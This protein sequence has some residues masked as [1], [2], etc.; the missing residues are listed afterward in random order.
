[1]PIFGSGCWSLIFLLF[2]SIVRFQSFCL[3]FGHDLLFFYNV[4]ILDTHRDLPEGVHDL[5]DD[6]LGRLVEL[7]DSGII[8]IWKFWFVLDHVIADAHVGILRSNGRWGSLSRPAIFSYVSSF[9]PKTLVHPRRL[10][11]TSISLLFESVIRAQLTVKIVLRIQ[12][13]LRYVRWQL[14]EA[15]YFSQ[16]V[17]VVILLLVLILLRLFYGSEGFSADKLHFI[18]FYFNLMYEIWMIFIY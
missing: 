6:L 8:W 15:R 10:R 1:M 5:R 18:H 11:S 13:L 7:G 9:V 17:I 2:D 3:V 4:L 14:W 16:V 12:F